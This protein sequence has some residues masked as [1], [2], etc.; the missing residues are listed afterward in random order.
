[1]NMNVERQI[2]NE[3]VEIQKHNRKKRHDYFVKLSKQIRLSY[4][5]SQHN[6]DSRAQNGFAEFARP[7]FPSSEFQILVDEGVF[8][9]AVN[10]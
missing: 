8:N 6:F 5:V 2:Y 1:M 10:H 4:K 7:Y 3:F 9:A